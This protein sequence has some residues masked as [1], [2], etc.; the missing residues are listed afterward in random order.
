[1]MITTL[2]VAC[3]VLVIK[4]HYTSPERD[5][6]QWLRTLLF[7]YIARLVCMDPDGKLRKLS[8][9]KKRQ[10]TNHLPRDVTTLTWPENI[11]T[12]TDEQLSYPAAYTS[13]TRSTLDHE[14]QE[15]MYELRHTNCTPTP[16]NQDVTTQLHYRI[17]Q[18]AQLCHR[19]HVLHN[20]YSPD[21]NRSGMSDGHSGHMGV[22]S[23]R[24]TTGGV[25][26]SIPM[27][28]TSPCTLM[29]RSN[30]L[31]SITS[32]VPAHKVLKMNEWKKLADILDRFL[33]YMFLVLLIV[34][35]AIIL[36]VVRLFK[37]EL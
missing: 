10:I 5:P 27:D 19:P 24:N 6:P 11:T 36:G 14:D 13:V 23:S 17:P 31:H 7:N 1:M 22:S 21:G 30:T 20:C 4:L 9:Q 32:N 16:P 25:E 35:T 33:F 26:N 34:P 18:N 3:A 2:S 15:E 12:G 29:S 8:Q 37:P 28:L